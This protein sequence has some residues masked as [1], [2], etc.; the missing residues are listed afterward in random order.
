MERHC[1]ANTYEH[2]PRLPAPSPLTHYFPFVHGTN[3][4]EILNEQSRHCEQDPRDVVQ[5]TP[6]PSPLSPRPPSSP[7][8]SSPCLTRLSV[9]LDPTP[10]PRSPPPLPHPGPPH[11]PHIR[12]SVKTTKRNTPGRRIS[13]KLRISQAGLFVGRCQ[14]RG[15][16]AIPDPRELRY[17][18]NMFS[19]IF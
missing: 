17:I 11:R 6:P 2:S 14:Q 12:F 19:S 15:K 10:H 4:N 8:N 7:V 13:R 5:R 16:D 9:T 1:R 3:A 18:E